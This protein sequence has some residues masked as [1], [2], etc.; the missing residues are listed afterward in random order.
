[1]IVA[2]VGVGSFVLKINLTAIDRS[3]ANLSI[4]VLKV[5]RVALLFAQFICNNS[6]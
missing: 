2:A 6:F 5:Q 1:M 4:P 3:L